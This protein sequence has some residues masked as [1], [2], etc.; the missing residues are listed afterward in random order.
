MWDETG[1]KVK[2]PMLAKMSDVWHVMVTKLNFAW[3]WFDT[4]CTG[5]VS[6]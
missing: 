5:G 2:I 6:V 1:Q 4:E 3:D